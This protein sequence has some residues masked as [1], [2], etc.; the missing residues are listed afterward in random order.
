ML[1]NS[2]HGTAV[3]DPHQMP[4]SGRGVFVDQGVRAE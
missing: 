2:E 4:K 3:E 1:V